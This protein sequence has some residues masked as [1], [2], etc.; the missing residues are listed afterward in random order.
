[1]SGN[2]WEWCEDRYGRYAAGTQIDPTGVDEGSYR[3]LRGGCWNSNDWYCRVSNR[4][5]NNPDFSGD[6]YGFRL[7]LEKDEINY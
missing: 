3:V 2:V 1:M 5:F 4:S 6:G 7:A